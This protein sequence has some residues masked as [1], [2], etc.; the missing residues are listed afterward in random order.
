MG[1]TLARIDL[2]DRSMQCVCLDCGA[3]YS[4]VCFRC[5]S[6]A[7]EHFAS[8]D[9]ISKLLRSSMAQGQQ[10]DLA[11]AVLVSLTAI[12]VDATLEDVR[13]GLKVEGIPFVLADR[14]G[15]LLPP[16]AE[17]ISRI[18]VSEQKLP[19]V[20]ERLGQWFGRA[21]RTDG[22]VNELEVLELP[23]ESVGMI[24]SR[25]DDAG[26]PYLVKGALPAFGVLGPSVQLQVNLADLPAVQRILS[27]ETAPLTEDA[28][29]DADPAVPGMEDRMQRSLEQRVADL[30]R[31]IQAPKQG[32][33]SLILRDASGAERLLLTV[34]D[35]G[36]AVSLLDKQGGVR[37]RMGM[38][39]DEFPSVDLYDADGEGHVQLSVPEGSP[40]VAVTANERRGDPCVSLNSAGLAITDENGQP[41]VSVGGTEVLEG[42]EVRTTSIASLELRDEKGRVVWQVSD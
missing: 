12:P 1:Q 16:F 23:R 24:Q 33:Q 31:Q 29:V 3:H 13:A 2:S 8:R 5:N 42:E 6:C 37:L 34:D 18:F 4:R 30:E 20:Q 25:L 26:I 41:R 21:Q 27:R 10:Y 9:E 40:E 28:H 39:M 11:S 15:N 38:V 19:L 35:A 14:E 7:S 32:G 22:S 17:S 36:P